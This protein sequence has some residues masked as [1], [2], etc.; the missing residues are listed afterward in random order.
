MSLNSNYINYTAADIEKYWKGQLTTTQMHALEKAAMDDPF[1]AD[2]LEGYRMAPQPVAPALDALAKR[3][4]ER[5]ED[6]KVVALP[7]IKWWRAAAAAVL[8]IG[9]SVLAYQLFFSQKQEIATVNNKVP[10]VANTVADSA[11]TTAPIIKNDTAIASNLAVA[12][13]KHIK[14]TYLSAAKEVPTNSANDTIAAPS[15]ADVAMT[16]PAVVVDDSKGRSAEPIPTKEAVAKKTD[17]GDNREVKGLVSNNNVLQGRLN[18][19]VLDP[20]NQ[21]VAG[22]IVKL[23]GQKNNIITQTDK[24]GNFSFNY[25]D[26]TAFASVS[27][28]GFQTQQL[29]LRNDLNFSNRIQLQPMNNAL[30]EVVVVGYGTDKKKNSNTA[31]RNS[32]LNGA[33]QQATPSVSMDAYNEYLDK[34]KRVPESLLAVHGDVVLSFEINNKGVYKDFVIEKSLQPQ[35]DA[36]AI[37]LV[38]EGPSWKL[39]A[40]RKTRAS[41]IV[42]F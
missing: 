22:A 1:L 33:V 24:L 8:L 2:A 7:K 40:G 15:G 31:P 35:L 42:R 10:A 34:N 14:P 18:G 21:P 5:V 20:M 25:T 23:E 4:T 19:V 28:V 12:K 30:N 39:V 26:S 37:R 38:K 41:V 3:L 9:S 6:K 32:K 17:A 11:N 36:E 13:T 29:Q 27:S 16:A